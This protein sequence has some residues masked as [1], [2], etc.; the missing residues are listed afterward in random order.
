MSD[1]PAYSPFTLSSA[2][3]QGLLLFSG[4]GT[5]QALSFLRN[6]IIGHAL[7]P[8][9][10]GI[11]AS[12]TLMLQI[13]ETLSDLGSD[14]LIVQ[15]EDGDKVEFVATAHTILVLRG[16]FLT[17]ILLAIG[18]FTARF[19]NIAQAT[20]AFQIVALVP[21]IK[22]F[23]HLDCRRAQRRFDNRPQMYVEVIPQAVALIATLPLLKVSATFD[24]VVWLSLAQA[25]AGVL[26][27]HLLSD[28]RYRLAVNRDILSRQIAFG[29]PILLSALPLI[30]VY[31]GD[32]LIIGRLS[33]MESLAAYTAC[34]M[35][36]MVPGLLAAKA[37]HALMLPLFSDALRRGR[38]LAS[39]FK[40][41]AEVTTLCA[42]LYLVFF[43]IA[44]ETLLP[45][46]F[47]AHYKGLGAVTAWLAAMW[48]LRMVQAVPGMA[49]M[50]AGHT[51]PF[52]IAGLVRAS[53][54]PFTL[55]TAIDGATIST[56]AGIAFFGECLSLLYVAARLESLEATT[57]RVLMTR[58][59]FLLPAALLAVLAQGAAGASLWNAAIALGASTAAVI[60]V[61]I[62]IMPSLRAQVRLR[63]ISQTSTASR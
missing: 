57:G 39:R 26:I 40:V 22:G 42:A 7:S 29:W 34:F 24:V 20:A 21:L 43:I 18:P 16:T 51:K 27:S 23:L 28:R 49:L 63:L 59:F 4:Y 19:F 10:F 37:G 62:A 54:L 11:A 3:T 1:T 2:G 47:G 46:V 50:A 9:D 13:V 56:I 14:R 36:T 32:R 33:G 45:L 31:Q 41:M 17:A 30:A 25:F 44:G 58:A 35:L 48:S 6:A 60:G 55:W 8:A 15:A 53:V 52:L 38:A 12:I 5:A 61:G